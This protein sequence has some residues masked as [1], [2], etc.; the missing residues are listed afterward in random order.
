MTPG[1]PGTACSCGAKTWC[2]CTQPPEYRDDECPSCGGRGWHTAGGNEPTAC[3]R[4]TA[5]EAWTHGVRLGGQFEPSLV[6]DEM[7]ERLRESLWSTWGRGRRTTDWPSRWQLRE[8]LQV[9]L[10]EGRDA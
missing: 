8:A 4:C 5:G 3:G 7:V 6:T 9:A 1:T 2:D 10:S